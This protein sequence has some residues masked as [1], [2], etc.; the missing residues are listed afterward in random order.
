MLPSVTNQQTLSILNRLK[1]KGPPAQGQVG[2]VSLDM[3]M[4]QPQE[5]QASDDAQILQ[6]VQKKKKP[7]PQGS[8]SS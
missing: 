5:D 6:P 3:T 1:E 2:D 4:P 8:M 7:V